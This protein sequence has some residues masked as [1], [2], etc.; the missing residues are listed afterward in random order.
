MLVNEIFLSIQGESISTGFPTIFVRF[1][2]CNL[3]CCY[4]DTTYAYEDGK[5]MSPYEVFE[6]VKRFHYKRVCITGGEPLLQKDLNELLRLLGDYAVTIETNGAVPIEDIT[7]CEGH[8]WV[9]D[10]KVPSSGCSNQMVLDNFRYLR[11][12]DEIKFVIGD[13]NDYDWA[14][15]IIKNHHYKGTITFSPV[16]GRIN[17]EDAVSWILADRLDVRFQ[18]QLHKIIWGVD[19]TGV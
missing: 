1:T 10:M 17:C 13:R 2:G 5:E 18:V 12:K 19:K 6:E 15:G 9:M 8:S 4:C 14:K 16:Y 3:R 7:L 11:D